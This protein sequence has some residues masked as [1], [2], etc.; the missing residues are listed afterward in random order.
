MKKN[1]SG[2]I[3]KLDKIFSLYI[4]L[5]FSDENWYCKCI[6]CGKIEHY[7]KMHCAHWISRWKMMY[8]FEENN[9]RPACVS[10]NTYRKEFHI[11]EFTMKQIEELWIEKVNEMRK[12]ANETKN[13]SITELENLIKFYTKEIEK[14]KEEK[15]V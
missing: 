15:K 5:K 4:R 7:T 10:C 2:L 11:R 9:C 12:N 6:S 8:R 13:F 14:L 3:K 1:K